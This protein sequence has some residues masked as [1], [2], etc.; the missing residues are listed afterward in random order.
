MSD[1]HRG[2]R[3]HGH[4]DDGYYAYDEYYET[5]PR[6]RS[7][8]RKTL[9]MLENLVI[10]PPADHDSRALTT[11]HHHHHRHPSRGSDYDHDRQLV[12]RRA[13]HSSSPTR[14]HSYYGGHGHSHHHHHHSHGHDHKDRDRD[15][16]RGR[17]YTRHEERHYERSRS[18]WDRGLAAAVDAAAIEAF[19]VRKEPGTWAG[20]K[21]RRVATAAISA[22][23][24]GA[25]TEHRNPDH[26]DSDKKGKL[27]SALGGL[28][29]NRLV[30]GPRRDLR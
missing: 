21:G 30:N 19:R 17:S 12:R 3:R 5:K 25:A 26:G 6:S 10:G 27:G 14:R 18:R 4:Y 11:T 2:R 1:H 15:R 29:V 28:V 7:I 22:G 20:Q 8:G 23:A 13:Y 24:I 16:H 9:D